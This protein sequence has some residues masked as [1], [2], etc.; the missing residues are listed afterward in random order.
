VISRTSRIGNGKARRIIMS[1]ATSGDSN[2]PF[3]HILHAIPPK[4]I[5]RQALRGYLVQLGDDTRRTAFDKQL[6]LMIDRG[7][8]KENG[9]R[10][11]L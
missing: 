2:N 6:A 1:H 10:L 11:F 5:S 3:R 7:L 4:G 8:L 9:G